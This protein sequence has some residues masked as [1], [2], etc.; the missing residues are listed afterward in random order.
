M[1]RVSPKLY[2]CKR[3]GHLEMITTNHYGQC[4]SAGQFNVCPTCPPWAK[5]PEFGGS[6]V[7]ECV[8]EPPVDDLHSGCKGCGCG[9]DEGC[10]CPPQRVFDEI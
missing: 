4:W 2:C 6:T 7:W 3:C 9:P 10:E 1:G 8:D 5:Y